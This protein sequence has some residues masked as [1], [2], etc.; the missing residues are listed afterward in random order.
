MQEDNIQ[1]GLRSIRT[2]RLVRVEERSYTSEE[3]G[4]ETDRYLSFAQ[5]LP[6]LKDDSLGSLMLFRYSNDFLGR[7]YGSYL[8]GSDVDVEDLEIVEYLTTTAAAP[9]AGGDPALFGVE[10]SRLEFD[11]VR[12]V[13]YQFP[14]GA[15]V[16]DKAL[17]RV[18]TRAE[19]QAM[20]SVPGLKLAM[21]KSK[22]VDVAAAGLAGSI[23]VPPKPEAGL[24]RHPVGVVDVRTVDGVTY[25]AISESVSDPRFRR[26]VSL[27]D[28]L[29]PHQQPWSDAKVAFGFDETHED[30]N[31]LLRE[32]WD[33][34]LDGS[35]V[36]PRGWS[37]DETDASG[38]RM[39]VVFRVEGPV[40]EQDGRVVR[41]ILDGIS[42][43]IDPRKGSES[44]AAARGRLPRA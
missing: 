21:L 7:P 9:S 18:F 41:R 25:A 14:T 30:A 27:V 36:W 28:G 29:D 3:F 38:A 37:L 39:V 22:S 4:D 44:K 40:R 23:I 12:D 16:G 10:V 19:T 17:M 20:Q 32:V 1:Y 35:S 11:L 6:Y 34:A 8:V 5:S 33:D 2:G 15:H 31:E 26:T 43:G 13:S 24:R 42:A